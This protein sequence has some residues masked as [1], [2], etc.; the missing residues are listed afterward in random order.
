MMRR[1]LALLA[2]FSWPWLATA[3]APLPMCPPADA[4]GPADMPRVL[5]R[6]YAAIE[7]QA[8][9]LLTTV[10]PWDSD[11]QFKLLTESRHD[12]HWVRP[13]TGAFAGFCFLCRFGAYD[14]ARTGVTREELL[15]SAVIP[16]GR[17][18][19]ATHVTGSRATGDGEPW[20]DQWQSAH[21]AHMLARGAWWVWHSLPEDLR[22]GVCRVIAHEA[23]RFVHEAPPHNLA[24]DTKAEENA[25]NCQALSTAIVLMP[26]DPRRPDWERAFQRWALSSFLRPADA[27]SDAVMDGR[28]LSEQFTGANI[29][30]DF[31][32]ENHGR[33]HPDYMSTFLLSAGCVLDF[34][35]TGRTPPQALF[36]NVPG[37]YENL[38]WFSLPGGG[39]VYP[40]GQDWELFRDPEWLVVHM[41]MAA[42][43]GDPDAWSLLRCCLDT[44]DK[45][46]A[47][48][49]SG[50]VYLDSEFFFPSTRTDQLYYNVLAW[51]FGQYRNPT[52]DAPRARLGV[53]ALEKGRI[54]LHR[55]ADAVHTIS[56]GAEIM[57]Q[58]VPQ[59]LD[60][61]T[62]PCPQSGI[63]HIR[64][65]GAKE[66]L[67]VQ[68]RRIA[69]D[70]EDGFSAGLDLVYG[71]GLAAARWRV[72]STPDGVMRW[73]ATLTALQD[74]E[75]EEVA[76]GL[77]GVLN[78]A[79]WVYERGVRNIGIDGA[80]HAVA[81]GS[82]EV[83]R[84]DGVH[85][86]SIDDVVHITSERPLSCCYRAAVKP[87]RARFTDELYLIYHDART[88]WPSG[89][90]IAELDAR[91]TAAPE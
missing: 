75:T 68:V 51:L 88:K 38:K 6:L 83:V 54:L 2:T 72:R 65:A 5:D 58:F 36:H 78:N 53:L 28:P 12:E 64:L 69:V 42:H 1:C 19:V 79:T 25:W 59:R 41:L 20:G 82:G 15:Q 33:I 84:R 91:L 62:S 40:N 74:I 70:R 21:W 45:M 85:A 10:H 61:V 48:T 26:D 16:M 4:P 76:A 18:L 77:I 39:F 13:N 22:E 50:A 46:Q 60:R 11:P 31:T 86:V 89:A 55:T 37:L 35:M 30:D 67:P 23:D 49:P 87:D 80:N 81:C 90:V 14:A 17:Y 66:A 34:A 24:D 8:R 56:W 43:G 27:A 57:V 32:L 3:W 9:Q 29:Y 47:R 63:G 71:D 7:G 73:Q 44:Q 52:V